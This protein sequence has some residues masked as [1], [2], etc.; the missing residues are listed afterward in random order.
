MDNEEF[1]IG[2]KKAIQ[3]PMMWQKSD[4]LYRYGVIKMK[5]TDD[6]KVVD[7]IKVVTIPYK[8]KAFEMRILVPKSNNINAL[9]IIENELISINNK[10]GLQDE[11][12]DQNKKADKEF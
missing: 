6:T 1:F 9:P 10:L 4:A 11:S 12:Q 2:N 3:V 8:N 7:D 5:N